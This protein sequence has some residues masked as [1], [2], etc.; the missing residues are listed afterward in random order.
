MVNLAYLASLVFSGSYAADPGSA[1]HESQCRLLDAALRQTEK[2]VL[3]DGMIVELRLH[4]PA[5]GP[6]PEA[7]EG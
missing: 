2:V 1:N 5:R 7:E 4:P 6:E 3:N